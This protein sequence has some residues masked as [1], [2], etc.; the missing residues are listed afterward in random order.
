MTEKAKTLRDLIESNSDRFNFPD[1][2]EGRRTFTVKTLKI[3]GDK[4]RIWFEGEEKYYEP[5]KGMIR[6]LVDAWPT[7][8]REW[9]GRQITLVG[10]PTVKYGGEAIGGIQ[11][12]ALSGIDGPMNTVMTL[13]RAKRVPYTVQPIAAKPAPEPDN[14]TPAD[15]VE[16][17]L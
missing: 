9:I 17:M 3:V 8:A 14:A 11:I 4:L 7:K 5:C 10:N 2:A 6:I 15:Q 13:N 12:V 1:F 16:A